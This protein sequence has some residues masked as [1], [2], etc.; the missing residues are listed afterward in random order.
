MVVR[1]RAALAALL[2][3]V[4]VG[5]ASSRSAV[6]A[7]WRPPVVA[8]VAD[9]FRPPT[10]RWC[11]GNRGIEYDTRP[12]QPV[13]AVESGRVTF[14]GAVAGTLYVVVEHRDGR[15]VTY[16]RLADLRHDRCD[17]VLRGQV[18]GTTGDA[19]H[20]GVRVGDRYADP[21]ES[22]GRLVGRPRLVPNDG[23]P[24]APGPAPALRC[25]PVEAR[26]TPPGANFVR[27]R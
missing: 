6:A 25:R 18:V 15:R 22:I 19:F 9:P 1:R 20:F 26:S 11:P 21:D 13:T 12:G 24:A 27:R 3:V 7:C 23:S 14:A 5:M 16:G 8:P 17:V 4:A 10:C 2:A